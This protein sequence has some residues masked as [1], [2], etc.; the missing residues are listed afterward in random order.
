MST[1]SRGTVQLSDWR[2]ERAPR[3]R[4]N[5]LH[6]KF[7]LLTS[8]WGK[9]WPSIHNLL[10]YARISAHHL[11]RK[12]LVWLLGVSYSL[13]VSSEIPQHDK[14]PLII[15]QRQ[16]HAKHGESEAAR[17]EKQLGSANPNRWSRGRPA[18]WVMED[19][20]QLVTCDRDFLRELIWADWSD[21]SWSDRICLIFSFSMATVLKA[22]FSREWT[23]QR[24]DKRR[25][26]LDA[27]SHQFLTRC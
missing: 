2:S 8:W 10:S 25:S 15:H 1:V 9:I 17:Y 14:S 6:D 4:V 22:D 12:W 7:F 19:R 3:S 13:C 24:E 27:L 18:T 23:A 21:W 20:G 5:E 16:H 11:Y 26:V